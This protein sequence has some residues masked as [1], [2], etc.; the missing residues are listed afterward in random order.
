MGKDLHWAR[1]SGHARGLRLRFRLVIGKSR[2]NK[3]EA[4]AKAVLAWDTRNVPYPTQC[5]NAL[6]SPETGQIPA[7]VGGG[8]VEQLVP[9]DRGIDGPGHHG[10]RGGDGGWGHAVLGH[11]CHV[12]A[13]GHA[14]VVAV[15]G[16]A[17]GVGE[18][19]CNDLD[20]ICERF[21]LIAGKSETIEVM[22]LEA[23]TA[24]VNRM[25][26]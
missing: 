2:F 23:G 26:L 18:V 15:E 17:V 7:P 19:G 10:G 25:D 24:D 22:G 13:A 4:Q 12:I 9:L 16:A 3:P 5:K 11:D 8:G 6:P 14:V 21:G 1:V 20:S